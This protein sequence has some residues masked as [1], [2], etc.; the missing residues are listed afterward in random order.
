MKCRR[1][2]FHKFQLTFFIPCLSPVHHHRFTSGSAFL[3][4]RINPAGTNPITVP[5]PPRPRH[6]SSCPE[7]LNSGRR[8][9]AVT[10]YQ[11]DK[12]QSLLSFLVYYIGNCWATSAATWSSKGHGLNCWPIVN[13]FLCR[14]FLLCGPI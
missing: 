1:F 10:G 11:T 7:W 3:P 9:G 6:L 14:N 2:H 12:R 13:I 8:K 4:E 5:C